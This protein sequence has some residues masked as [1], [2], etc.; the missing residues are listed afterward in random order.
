[1]AAGDVAC[2]LTFKELTSGQEA[3][4]SETHAFMLSEDLEVA[5]RALLELA[6]K[7]V[8]LLGAGVIL[9]EGIVSNRGVWRDS[10][11][12]ENLIPEQTDEGPIYNKE[13]NNGAA[14]PVYFRADYAYT[15]FLTRLE[16]SS[17]PLYRR[18]LWLPG[19][20]DIAQDIAHRSPIFNAA[21]N[22][23]WGAFQAHL[24]GPDP[25]LPSWGFRV[26][27][28]NPLATF[29]SRIMAIDPQTGVMTVRAKDTTV[30][31]PAALA[32]G[33]TVQVRNVRG[34]DPRPAGAY[35]I[36]ARTDSGLTSSIT[37]RRVG[38]AGLGA[39]LNGT[40][41]GGGWMRLLR[42]TAVPYARA[43]ERRFGSRR[44]SGPL[45]P[46]KAKRKQRAAVV[47]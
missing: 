47:R 15:Q 31:V 12:M 21:W 24:V 27:N 8:M 4:W 40:Y 5:A 1:M 14:T 32:V 35:K 29:E 28:R 46:L 2:R 20:P 42:W 30:N 18:S 39:P 45:A 11:I 25:A 22:R 3:G 38:T 17:S 44:V 6:R 26:K 7:R 34:F 13:F 33:E 10:A 37:L 41:K 19:C 9:E 43:E 36:T 23:A 16:S